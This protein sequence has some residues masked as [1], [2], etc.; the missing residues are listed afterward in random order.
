MELRLR[1]EGTRVWGGRERVAYNSQAMRLFE[2]LCLL[3]CM[4]SEEV[5]DDLVAEI[6]T[7][8]LRRIMPLEGGAVEHGLWH[9]L[10]MVG[11]MDQLPEREVGLLH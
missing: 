5:A 2:S 4:P 3:V 9:T 8:S 7:E 1:R 6:T 11:L 10:R